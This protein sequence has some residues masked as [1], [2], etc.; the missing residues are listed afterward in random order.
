M[1]KAGRSP[2]DLDFSKKAFCGKPNG[3][4]TITSIWWS[5]PCSNGTGS[6]RLLRRP[7]RSESQ[8]ILHVP[9]T[10][11][12]IRFILCQSLHFTV[13]HGSTE[14]DFAVIACD[15]NVRC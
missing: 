5:I 6:G 8:L 11:D 4:T 10:P 13:L 3:Y 15:M 9:H 7:G 1:R 2:K 12:A 14:C